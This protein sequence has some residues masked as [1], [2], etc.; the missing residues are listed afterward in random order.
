MTTFNEKNDLKIL[1]SQSLT[2]TVIKL[3]SITN[4]TN[5]Y[6]EYKFLQKEFV[7]LELELIKEKIDRESYENFFD[8]LRIK[9][10]D[11]IEKLPIG[12]L[13]SNLYLNE[14][15]LDDIKR[16]FENNLVELGLLSNIKLYGKDLALESYIN[17]IKKCNKRFLTTSFL[18]SNF[19]YDENWN[20]VHENNQLQTRISNSKDPESGLYRLFIIPESI[21]SYI[22][23]RVDF[24]LSQ[25]K[26]GNEK[27]LKRIMDSKENLSNFVDKIEMK[28]IEE[29]EIPKSFRDLHGL[30]GKRELALYDDFRFDQFNLNENRQIEDIEICTKFDEKFY[31]KKEHFNKNFKKVWE[32]A[33]AVSVKEY[34]K[35]I[36]EEIAEQKTEKIDY[37]SNWLLKYDAYVANDNHILTSEIGSV[38]SYLEVYLKAYCNGKP[39]KNYLDIGVC[40]GRYPIALRNGKLVKNILTVD[41]DSDVEIFMNTYRKDIPF[42]R[43]DIRHSDI[44]NMIKKKFDLI[45]C[46]LG[47]ICHF[48]LNIKK[49]KYANKTG[50]EKALIN[51]DHLLNIDGLLIISSWQ[52]WDVLK[53][54]KLKLYSDNQISILKENNPSQEKLKK[55][56]DNGN[57]MYS[58]IDKLYDPFFDIYVIKKIK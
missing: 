5:F 38:T 40:T 56:L 44:R 43:H 13:R 14:V 30:I 2:A 17:G 48:G 31:T 53:N 28:I 35:M 1:L 7:N 49:D 57:S 22:S 50:L 4:N 37:E 12:I 8:N 36:N 3:G 11:L 45:T 41:S 18:D 16:K 33:S 15:G 58:F 6:K 23:K 24:A 25:E 26:V 47:T 42:I 32:S 20:I 29:N 52:D 54:G 55:I 34:I 27:P 46:M 21:S 10:L 19:W 39:F 51:I 9:V